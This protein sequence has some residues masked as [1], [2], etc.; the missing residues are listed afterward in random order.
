[1]YPSRGF[2][3]TRINKWRWYTTCK[4][5]TSLPKW[6]RDRSEWTLPCSLSGYGG[7]TFKMHSEG[8]TPGPSHR[9]VIVIDWIWIAIGPFDGQTWV[10]WFC[11]MPFSSWKFIANSVQQRKIGRDLGSRNVA[12]SIALL[13]PFS[14]RLSVNLQFW[15]VGSWSTAIWAIASIRPMSMTSS[16]RPLQ[17][18]HGICKGPLK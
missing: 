3:S 10:W 15:W 9:N 18:I 8:E 7:W 6:L 1:M 4:R 11:H 16:K 17:G 12:V 13:C 2:D 5:S 14:L